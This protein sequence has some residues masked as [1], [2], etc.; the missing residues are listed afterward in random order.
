M[1]TQNDVVQWLHIRPNWQQDAAERF[2]SKGKLSESDIDG[3]SAYSKT[4]DGKANSKSRTYTGLSGTSTENTSVRLISIGEIQ[5]IDNLHPRKPLSLGDKNLVVVYGKNGSG[6]SGYVRILQKACGKPFAKTLRSNVFE[7]PGHSRCCKIA[8]E[9]GGVEQ[10][11]DWGANDAPIPQLTAVDVFDSDSGQLYLRKDN[12]TSYVPRPVV[13]FDE[14]VRVCKGVK[15]RLELEKAGFPPRLPTIPIE[16]VSTKAAQLLFAMKAGQTEL[17]LQPLINWT[18]KDQKELED[19]EERLK[20]KDPATIATQK[21]NQKSQIQILVK[22]IEDALSVL[23][24]DACTKM[25]ALSGDATRHRRVASE[26]AAAALGHA[27]LDG[28]GTETWRALWEAARRYSTAVAYPALSFPN[29]NEG[30]RCVLCHQPLLADAKVR[31]DQ[32]EEYVTGELET[33]AS[34]AKERYELSTR[35]LPIRP[36]SSTLGTACI[37]AGL[38][39]REWVERFTSFWD[40]VEDVERRGKHEWIGNGVFSDRFLWIADLKS[41]MSD[42]DA[43]AQQ[44]EADVLN[45]DRQEAA[46]EQ[47]ELRARKWAS[48]QAD[49]LKAELKRLA[50]V[51]Q[52]EQLIRSTDHTFISKKAGE[53]AEKAITADYIKRFNAELISLGAARIRVELVKSKTNQGKVL[54]RIRLKGA[55]GDVSPIDVLSEGE[56]KVIELAGFLADVTGRP[57]IS[58]FVFDDPISSLDQDFEERTIDRLIELS[59]ERQVIVFTHRL[60]FLGTMVSKSEH[61]SEPTKV[62]ITHE[63]WGA[64]EPGDLP[65]FAKSPDGALRKLRNERLL[66]AENAFAKDGSELYVPLAKSI[67][68]EIRIQIERIVEVVL[69]A[70][71]IQRHRREVNTKGKIKN[72]AKITI[73]D[74]ALIE[75]LMTRYSCF[76]HSQSAE[77]PVD[78]PLPDSIRSDL[79]RMLRWLEEFKKR[80][81]ATAAS[82]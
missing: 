74:C 9:G 40:V 82:A 18:Q 17:D 68:T 8:F 15:Q 22:K 45:F 43:E 57:G 64:G 13:V 71:V 69:L 19:L 37:A 61:K 56:K 51:A 62:G 78:V 6:K 31:L 4:P 53:V 7:Q 12:E 73:D 1:S 27:S 25:N 80:S 39:E 66:Q 63:P 24:P 77:A 33:A 50:T 54:H 23:S 3:I 65:M 29:T 34:A 76:E 32:F 30:G 60:S 28:V 2:L 46:K 21:R 41:R 5:G 70:D 36:D 11:V 38:S 55:N 48:E 58:P 26:A 81:I 47:I 20:A 79:D 72:L 14:L 42:L 52:Y 59:A 35:G 10:T 16:Y 67:C 49:S 44:Y 75:E